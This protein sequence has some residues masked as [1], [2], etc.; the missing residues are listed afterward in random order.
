MT[1]NKNT[2]LPPRV[3]SIAGSDSG[4]GAGIQADLKTAQAFGVY[5]TT[6]IT[7]ITAQN[8][9][10]V[11][12]VEALSPDMV[13]AQ[14]VSVLDDIG[15]DCIKIGMLA[16]QAIIERVAKVLDERAQDITVVLDPVL[17]STSG[18]DL[19]EANA[20]ECMIELLVP[21][22]DLITPNS[23]E[24]S[25]LTGIV[26]EDIETASKAG[27]ALLEMGAFAALIKG[28]HMS[29]GKG[30]TIIDILVNHE[31]SQI[32]SAPRIHSRHTH[33]TGC[34]LS[35]AIAAQLAQGVPLEIAVQTGREFVFEAIRSAPKIG[36]R[37]GPLG[38]YPMNSIENQS[39]S[40]PE[41]S[42]KKSP[43]AGLKDHFS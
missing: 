4:A 38:H 21:M 11:Q 14:I 5:C 18:H 42:G 6:A 31:G 40:A 41:D 29:G 10:G 12:A 27:D 15:V 13:E 37:H 43:F 9:T 1:D 26:V 30:A 39:D 24:A 7:A 25:K 34:T 2:D 3:L 16:N 19:L 32:M 28:G 23:I 33:G 8:T 36:A 22:A 17:V 20:L 35:S